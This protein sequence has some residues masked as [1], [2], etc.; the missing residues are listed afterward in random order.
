MFPENTGLSASRISDTIATMEKYKTLTGGTAPSESSLVNP[1]VIDGV[2]G[3]PGTAKG[4]AVD[5]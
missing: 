1:A 5:Q 4:K 3:Q 2:I